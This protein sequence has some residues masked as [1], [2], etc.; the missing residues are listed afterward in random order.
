MTPYPSPLFAVIWIG[1]LVSW[2]A[3]SSWSGLTVKRAASWDVWAYR[4]IIF[5]G[6]ILLTP[7]A[8]RLLAAPPLWNVGINGS[9]ALAAIALAGISFT[10]WA[11]IRLGRLWSSVITRK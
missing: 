3:A 10:W 1:W 9:Y 4:T 11:R 2:M 5:V 6:A 8:A 7:W